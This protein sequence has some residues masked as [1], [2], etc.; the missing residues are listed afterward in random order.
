MELMTPRIHYKIN[1]YWSRDDPLFIAEV[2][3]LPGCGRWGHLPGGRGQRRGRHL[4]EWI[5]TAIELGRPVPEPR[6]CLMYA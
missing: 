6:G 4:G 2:P 1:L 3:E 5:E